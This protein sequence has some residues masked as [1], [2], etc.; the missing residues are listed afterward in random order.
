MIFPEQTEMWCNALLSP[1]QDLPKVVFY[2]TL[3]GVLWK[4]VSE[5]ALS[6]QVVG[7]PHRGPSRHLRR[8]E[9]CFGDFLAGH[10]TGPSL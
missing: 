4:L 8:T 3:A 6:R 1:E 5:G 9:V 7:L 2:R 10:T